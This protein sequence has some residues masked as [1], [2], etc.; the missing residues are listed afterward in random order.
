MA[1]RIQLRRDTTANWESVDPILA[2]GEPGYDIVTNEIR[3]GDGSTAWTGLS[4][5]TISGSG[6]VPTDIYNSVGSATVG[7]SGQTWQFSGT[8]GVLTLPRNSYLETSDAN[9][10]IGSPGNV[11]IR[12]NASTVGGTHTW[13]FNKDGGT[14]FPDGGGGNP[15]T[16]IYTTS[17]GSQYTFESYYA[18]GR[19]TGTYLQLD[20]DNGSVTLQATSGANSPQLTFNADGNLTL[21]AGGTITEGNVGLADA[22]ILTPANVS[23]PGQQLRI[24]STGGQ[25]A[26]GNHLHLTT[27]N[28]HTSEL[29][30]GDDNYFVKLNNNGNIQIR[31]ATQSL[32][33]T[34]SWMFSTDGNLTVPGA[35]LTNSNSQLQMTESANT[36][37][38]GT[39]A[40]DSTAL[41][42]TATTAELY[43]N[44]N[45]Y[46]TAGAGGGGG[47]GWTFGTDGNLTLPGNLILPAGGQIQSESGT[48]NVTIEVND[49]NNVRAWAFE[50]N[51]NITFPDATTQGTAYR[52]TTGSWTVTTGSATYRFT[53][54]Q[55]GTYTMWV[56][57]L[58]DNGII[59]WNATATVTNNNVPVLG[60]QYAWVYSGGGTPIDFTDIPHQFVGTANTIVRS[61]PPVTS[62]TNR[63]DFVINNT[64]GSEQTVYW[65][66]VAQ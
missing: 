66:Y 45:V 54:P 12:S 1:N 11:T 3:I 42:L 57:G 36:A 20:A 4:G 8:D 64:S 52:R 41:Y 63:F 61:D 19:G 47:N 5:N 43:A 17:G 26:E 15:T 51:G 48:G 7:S 25:P 33:A 29:Y 55:T 53:V 38:L 24:Y 28:L 39:T 40:N 2:D 31:A 60:Q 35:I 44:T 18:G 13:N 32:S 30:L 65:G 10:K 21:P 37:Y 34:A 16:E 6:G 59:T 49:G 56:R 14:T 58:C 27:G 46:I 22:L 9:L 23:Y 50:T 62:P